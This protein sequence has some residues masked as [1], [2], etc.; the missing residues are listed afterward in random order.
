MLKKLEIS[1]IYIFILIFN[2]NAG[3]DGELALKKDQPEKIKD[4]FENLNRAT[5]EFNQGL[6]NAIFKPIAKGYKNLPDPIQRGTSNAARNLSNLITIP[7]NILQG[8]VKTAMINTGRL[9]VNTTVG[10]LG[11]I[12]VANKMGFP[13]YVKEDYGQ[14]LGSWGVGSGCYLVLPV[15]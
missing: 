5:F 4:C 7:N 9:V 2:A 14:T 12:D 13:K 10:L 11:T 8:D 15:L 3:S 6:D 1:T